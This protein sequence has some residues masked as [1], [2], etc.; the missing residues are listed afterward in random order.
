[1][2]KVQKIEAELQKLSAKEMVQVRELLDEILQKQS[3]GA[4]TVGDTQHFELRDE[5]LAGVREVRA[6]KVTP[7]DDAAV[8]RIK[9]RGRKLLAG[10]GP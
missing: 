2:S 7:F 3:E 6:G 9:A 10:V 4:G 5:V 8:G 1:M